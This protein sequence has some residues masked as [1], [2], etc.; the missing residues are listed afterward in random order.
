[1]EEKECIYFVMETEITSC[2]SEERAKKT[3]RG[4]KHF[5]PEFKMPNG[6][7]LSNCAV[8]SPQNRLTYHGVMSVFTG[9]RISNLVSWTQGR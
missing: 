4:I 6:G 8:F 9:E 3:S 2:I 7:I 5:S 1:M